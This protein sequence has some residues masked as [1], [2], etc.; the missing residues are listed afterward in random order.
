MLE[1]ASALP[2]AKTKLNS[3]LSIWQRFY[4]FENRKIP[5]FGK[6]TTSTCFAQEEMQVYAHIQTTHTHVCVGCMCANKGC[7]IGVKVKERIKERK[8]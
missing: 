5:N 6:V 4:K 7:S 8:K 1:R 2:L 3:L